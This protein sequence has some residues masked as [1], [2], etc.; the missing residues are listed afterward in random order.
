MGDFRMKIDRETVIVILGNTFMR[1]KDHEQT[2][3]IEKL[4]TE[5]GNKCL[6][7]PK[8][9]EKYFIQAW[10]DFASEFEKDLNRYFENQAKFKADIKRKER[11]RKEWLRK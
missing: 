1:M 9:T 8:I 2:I 7:L 5:N 3:L 6:S 4:K 10:S 11:I